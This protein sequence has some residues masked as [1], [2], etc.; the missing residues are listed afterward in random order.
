MLQKQNVKKGVFFCQHPLLRTHLPSSVNQCSDKR[1]T[2][3]QPPSPYIC[4]ARPETMLRFHI[5]HTHGH[6][7]SPAGLYGARTSYHGLARGAEIVTVIG[8]KK[9]SFTFSTTIV[10]SQKLVRENWPVIL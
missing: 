9:I 10:V 6:H 8:E 1:T 3:K 5:P 7:C 4:C 2:D